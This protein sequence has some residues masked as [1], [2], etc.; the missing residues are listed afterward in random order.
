M[1]LYV[2]NSVS[3]MFRFYHCYLQICHQNYSQCN[4]FVWHFLP[5]SN[6]D[7]YSYLIK[8]EHRKLGWKVLILK[9]DLGKSLRKEMCWKVAVTIKTIWLHIVK[10]EK[11]I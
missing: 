3:A 1:F 6:S 10:D 7:F 11:C 2:V 8:L 4:T 5:I 9:Y